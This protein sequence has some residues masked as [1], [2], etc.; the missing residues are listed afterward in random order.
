MTPC[1]RPAVRWFGG[2]WRLAPWILEHIPPH[3]TYVE[4]Y[5]GGA[6][7]LIRKRPSYAEVYNDLDSEI[8]NLFR[9]LRHPSRS[10]RLIEKLALT[11]FARDEFEAAYRDIKDPVERARRLVVLSFMGFGSNA[12]TKSSTG[13]RANSNRNGT[14]PAFDWAHYPTAL[15]AIVERLKGGDVGVVIENRPAIE[16]MAQHDGDDTA[17]YLDPPYIHDTRTRADTQRFYRHEMSDAEHREMLQFAR[18]LKGAVT[19]SAYPHAIYDEVLTG[20]TKVEKASH[21]DGAR[22]RLE[23]LW[24]NPRCADAINSP[25]LLRHVA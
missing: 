6:S 14:T 8:V 5:G 7:V 24:L 9:V 19:L 18:T 13:F 17:H 16:C 20:W 3:R 2:K 12:H 15:R 22:K 23:V 1:K 11:P 10:K 4:P 25:M 21:A